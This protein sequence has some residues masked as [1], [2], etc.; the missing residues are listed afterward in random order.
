MKYFLWLLLLFLAVYI[1]PLGSR[2]AVAPD[3]FRYAQIPM[4]MIQTGNY[5]VPHMLGE[6][7]FEKPVLGYWLNAGSFK[8]FGDNLFAVRFPAAFLTGLT[9]LLVGLM[10][11]QRLRDNRMALLSSAVFLCSGMVYGVGTFAVLDSQMVFFSTGA[12]A[13][14][15]AY[16]TEEGSKLRRFLLL[17]LCG[18]FAGLGFMTK[19]VPALV[20]PGLAV[21][22]FLITEKRF[23]EFLKMPWIP[24]LFA[25]AVVLPWAVAVHRADGDFWRYF[26]EVEHIERF[27]AANRNQHEAA[28]WELLLPFFAGTL[29]ASLLLIPAVAG[30][31]AVFK[32]VRSG[33]LFRYCAFAAFLPLILFSCSS[34]KLATYILPCFPATAV[35]IALWYVTAVRNNPVSEKTAGRLFIILGWFFAVLGVA[36]VAFAVAMDHQWLPAI[37]NVDQ[38][39]IWAVL[40]LLAAAGASA[41][42]AG[43][44]QLVLFRKN[45]RVRTGGFFAFLALPALL[46]VNFITP[47][48]NAGKMPEEELKAIRNA[49]R[50]SGGNVRIVTNPSLMHACARVFATS[51]VKL[52]NSIGEMEYGNMRALQ[53]GREKVQIDNLDFE[54]LLKRSDRKNVIYV[55]WSDRDPIRTSV[56][57]V[58][59]C[60]GREITG[61]YFPAKR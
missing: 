36:A 3:E 9:A 33:K 35:M 44:I 18:V 54:N 32:Q 6:P 39:Q 53:A 47:Q 49:F 38:E 45:I 23:K 14:A 55:F 37:P 20:T 27:T 24:L 10:V 7:Y 25:V 11:W 17:A 60:Q 5:V 8:L 43:I 34:G 58:S 61:W 52:L 26:V 1:I 42:A 21:A 4:E 30:G 19:G 56:K 46:A 57:P 12:L 22:A 50:V 29:P 15:F 31:K 16:L 28:W 40:P 2:P 59:N 51:D 48:L 41:A 13:C